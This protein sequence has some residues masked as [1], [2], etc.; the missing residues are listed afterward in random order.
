MGLYARKKIKGRLQKWKWL[1][2]QLSYRGR[3][4]IINNLVGSSLWHKLACV[5]PLLPKLQGEMVN[6]FWDNLHW[7]PQSVLFLPRDEGGQGLINLV[8]RGATYRLQFIQRLLM[9]PQSLVWKPLAQ[10]ILRGVNGMGLHAALFLMDHSFLD[11]T[12]LPSFYK[13]LFKVWRLFKHQWTESATSLFWLLEE[14]VVFGSRL[15][16][17]GDDIPGL[18]DLLVSKKLLQLKDI[19][20]KAGPGL[21]NAETVAVHLGIRSVRFARKFL[22]K[23]DGVL[24]SKEKTLLEEYNMGLISTDAYDFFPDIRIIPDFEKS[25]YNSPL[26]CLNKNENFDF[27]TVKGKVLYRCFVKIINKNTLK[28]RA[29]TVWRDKLGVVEEIKPEWRV[30]YKPPLT[31]RAGDLQWRI[32]HGAIAVNAFVTK[33][34]PTINDNC[35]FCSQRET[36]FHCFMNC[37]RLSPLFDLLDFLFSLLGISFTKQCFILGF[38]YSKLQ[39]YRCQL[40]NFIVGQAKMA[41]YISRRNKIEQRN[42]QHIVAVFKNMFKSRILVDFNY[43]KLMNA[44]NVFKIEW[45]SDVGMCTV[46]ND[47]LFFIHELR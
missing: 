29:D 44:I 40:I 5:D 4:L 41:I 36:V 23:L 16:V 20:D 33:M 12:G 24:N 6:F 18:K 45:C 17:S 11:L 10:S 31:K 1:L 30:L 43:Y 22:D 3:T 47:E 9:G 35:P 7:T 21:K 38:K 13:S 34:N 27:C 25:S 26:L 46:L 42:G 14:P 39:K 19:V 2:P 32:L 15:D 37:D 28:D 8:S